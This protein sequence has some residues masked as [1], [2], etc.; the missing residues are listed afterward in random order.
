MCENFSR[1]IDNAW[2]GLVVGV[3]PRRGNPVGVA[4]RSIQAG[5]QPGSPTADKRVYIN[6]VEWVSEIT[7]KRFT[8]KTAE[9]FVLE[10]D[11]LVNGSKGM[12]KMEKARE[13]LIRRL[14]LYPRVPIA[15]S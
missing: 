8:A 3:S 5:C 14:S 10:W 1:H 13:E 2:L 12:R 15:S 6:I 9:E 4:G 7:K 11:E